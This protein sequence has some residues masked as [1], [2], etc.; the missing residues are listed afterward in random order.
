MLS[1]G[2][3]QPDRGL[4]PRPCV[5]L[6][7]GHVRRHR[8]HRSHRRSEQRR[9][10]R[11]SWRRWI[12]RRNLWPCRLPLRSICSLKASF[13]PRI[14]R[15]HVHPLAADRDHRLPWGRAGGRCGRA[16]LRA[17]RRAGHGAGRRIPGQAQTRRGGEGRDSAFLDRSPQR[18]RKDAKDTE[19]FLWIVPFTDGATET[20][21][22]N[23]L[24][25]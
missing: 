19:S 18:T 23:Q 16:G 5:L 20:V 1:H 9:L 22:I 15:S 6:L 12:H 7:A 4:G 25:S 3:V 14:M 13:P 10:W 24:P 21:C 2:P 11:R 17:Y 8:E